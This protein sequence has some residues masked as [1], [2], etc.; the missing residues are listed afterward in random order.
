MNDP[1][2]TVTY[3]QKEYISLS[4]MSDEAKIDIGVQ[5][6][7]QQQ[8]SVRISVLPDKLSFFCPSSALYDIWFSWVQ[9]E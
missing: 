3:L 1:T 7:Q 2:S 8:Q 6:Q 9:A 5:Q 4:T